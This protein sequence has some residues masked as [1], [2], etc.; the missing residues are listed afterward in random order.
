[1]TLRLA[2]YDATPGT[3]STLARAVHA[4]H[5]CTTT[6]GADWASPPQQADATAGQVDTAPAQQAEPA[7]APAASAVKE[8]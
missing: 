3:A 5:L 4:D 1:M 6:L 7:P 8:G 2:T